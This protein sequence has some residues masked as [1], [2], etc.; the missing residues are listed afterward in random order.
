MRVIFQRNGIRAT[1]FSLPESA[2]QMLIRHWKDFV[3][4][5]PPYP[6]EFE[7]KG[8]VICAGGK[9]Y[10]TCCWILVNMLRNELKCKLPIQVWYRGNEITS[11]WM[12]ALSDLKVTCHNLEDYYDL[13]P[14]FKGYAMKPMAILFSSFKEI[15]YLDADNMCTLT[16][17]FL[18]DLP[19]Y[20]RFGAVFWPDFWI[21]DIHNQIWEIMGVP[22][23]DG[24]EQ[25]SGQILINKERCWAE[26]NL[27]VYLNLNHRIYYNYLLGDKDTFRFA[28]LA[29]KKPF[30]FIEHGVASCGYIDTDGLFI[31]NTMAQYIPDG[32][33]AFLHR[34][35]LKWDVTNPQMR[36]WQKI[37]AFPSEAIAKRYRLYRDF[38][39]ERDVMDIEGDITM[40]DFKTLLGDLE[41]RCLVY[42]QAL[43][44]IYFSCSVK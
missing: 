5:I 17:D 4:T 21:T 29:L 42:L 6:N 13:E 37:K 25:E 8:I 22:A 26:I 2:I 15:L 27:A 31:G 41:D 28:W 11:D 16:P 32:R 19:Q 7:G 40:I 12:D 38:R 24:K 44:D 23:N 14:D 1:D 20:K 9:S 30:Y 36:A 10:F 43:H 34:N 33:I 35:L 3:D 18:F 39:A